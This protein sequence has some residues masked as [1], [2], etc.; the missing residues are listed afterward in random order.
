[1]RAISQHVLTVLCV[2]SVALCLGWTATANADLLAHWTFDETSGTTAADSTGN[3]YNGTITGSTVTQGVTGAIGTAF[4]FVTSGYVSVTSASA[5]TGMTSA[6]LTS[7]FMMPTDPKGANRHMFRSAYTAGVGG[8]WNLLD[9]LRLYGWGGGDFG[10]KTSTLVSPNWQQVTWTT[11]GVGGQTKMYVNGAL[12]ATTTATAMGSGTVMNLGGGNANQSFGND[13]DDMGIWD[14]ALTAA[15]VGAI[16]NTPQVAGLQAT[17]LYNLSAMEQLF[18]LYAAGTGSVA[19][20]GETWQYETGLT[21]HTA[22]DAWSDGGFYYVQLGDGA[23][24]ST[25]PE[26]S[27]LALLASGLI[28]LL[29]YAWRKRK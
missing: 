2:F 26:P 7:W 27:T 5:L 19:I 8:V 14:Q 3:G 29:C 15:E 10:V 11:E 23:G 25:I 12:L 9:S 1:M 16:Y 18:D 22:G 6:S 17:G 21:G 28:G 20:G 24:V 13:L 4:N